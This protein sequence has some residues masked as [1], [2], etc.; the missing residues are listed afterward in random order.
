MTYKSGKKAQGTFPMRPVM[1]MQRQEHNL[2]TVHGADQG[3]P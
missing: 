3:G 1:T 2:G